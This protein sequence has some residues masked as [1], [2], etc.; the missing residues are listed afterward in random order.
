MAVGSVTAAARQDQALLIGVCQ[1]TAAEAT[2]SLPKLKRGA[3]SWADII[4]D[5]GAC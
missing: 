1:Q 3:V 2:A 4:F 5:T